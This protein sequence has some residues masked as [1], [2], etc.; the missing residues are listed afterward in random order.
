MFFTSQ[1][2]HLWAEQPKQVL[3]I[4]PCE[5]GEA[6]LLPCSSFMM[7]ETLSCWGSPLELINAGFRDGMIQATWSCFLY[8]FCEVILR[9]LVV[10]CCSKSLCGLQSLNLFLFLDN[11]LTVGLCGRTESGVLTL[12]FIDVT[13]F[14]GYWKDTLLSSLM[15]LCSAKFLINRAVTRGKLTRI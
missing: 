8:P 5:P 9:F 6:G 13:L 3:L 11:Y 14:S 4:L 1:L 15:S 12:P 10:L 2:C 7:R